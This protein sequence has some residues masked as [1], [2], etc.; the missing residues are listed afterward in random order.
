[1]GV[2]TA[3]ILGVVLPV[4]VTRPAAADVR[5]KPA[6]AV[7]GEGAEI[8]F[9]ISEDRAPAVTV[10]CQIV[11][12]ELDA[13]AEVVPLSNESW[14]P[15]TDYR[16]EET[17][18]AVSSITWS[19]PAPNSSVTV[20]RVSDVRVS[21]GPMPATARLRFSVVQ[22]YSDGQVK[23]WSPVMTLQPPGGA[24]PQD[25][26]APSPRTADA[27]AA[28]ESNQADP[29]AGGSGSFRTIVTVA[30]PVAL[31]L[32]LTLGWAAARL[33]LR[34]RGAHSLPTAD[35]AHGGSRTE[36]SRDVSSRTDAHS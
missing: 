4:V 34:R 30:I 5:V 8:T 11:F 24:P 21:M 35:D 20:A 3:V 9:S 7:Q 19:R 26:A 27:D 29:V 36:S 1:M 22:R 17:G 10:E 2:I 15:R 18:P 12:P 23:R 31:L 16:T 28:R 32:G 6:Q 13:G 25:Q 33:R 14:A